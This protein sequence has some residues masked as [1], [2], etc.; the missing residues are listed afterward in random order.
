MYITHI[1]RCNKCFESKIPFYDFINGLAHYSEVLKFTYVCIAQ[2]P[3]KH[4][5]TGK[6]F[7]PRWWWWSCCLQGGLWTERS[8]VQ[9]LITLYKITK[10]CK[11]IVSAL[12]RKK[13]KI[14][15]ND[16]S[17]NTNLKQSVNNLIHCEILLEICSSRSPGS[18]INFFVH[19]LP[20][21]NLKL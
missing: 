15:K 1:T 5:Y 11:K 2:K 10:T 18:I 7:G 14:N 17:F 19:S 16:P 8:L 9:F 4:A 20:E 3:K 13:W 12:R 6:L 21:A